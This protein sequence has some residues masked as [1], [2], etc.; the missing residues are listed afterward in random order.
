MARTLALATLPLLL[1]STALAQWATDTAANQVVRDAPSDQ[2]Q[3]KVVATGDGGFWVSWFD[4]LASGWDVRLQRYDLTGEA[5]FPPGGLLVADR[6]LSSTQDYGL[7]TTT[8]GDA[9]LAF[10]DDRGAGISIT[11]ARISR[12]GEQVWGPNGVTASTGSAFIASPRIVRATARGAVVAWTETSGV[13]VQRLNESG[14]PAWGAGVMIAPGLGSYALADMAPFV[15]DTI[16]SIVHQT[17]GFTSPR[18]LVAQ[19]LD[20]F[21]QPVW[22]ASPVPVFDAGSL[23][24]GSFPPVTALPDGGALFAWYS[25]SPTLQ[26]FVQRLDGS[27]AP[28]FA[29]NGVPVATTPGAVRVNPRASF[30]TSTGDVLVAWREQDPGQSMAGISAQRIDTSGARVWTDAG[31]TVVPTGPSLA[32]SPFVF[33]DSA[34]G[35][36]LVTWEESPS[37]GTD[38][39]YGARLDAMG[40]ISLPRFDIAS[41]PSGKARVDAARSTRDLV[42][43]AWSD[44]RS[45]G[46]DIYAQAIGIDGTPGGETYIVDTTCVGTVNFSG[47]PGKLIARGS[48]VVADDDLTLIAYDL[49]QHSFA[50]C[51]TSQVFAIV[52]MPG[53]SIG[54]LCLGGEIGRYVGPGQIMNSMFGGTFSLDLD[55]DRVPTPTGLVP[56]S[57]GE[58]WYFQAWFRDIVG[59]APRS[60]F[61]SGLR[62]VFQ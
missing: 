42:L 55:L 29:V 19:R 39:L 15:E 30:E 48:A 59:A 7:A 46:G 54:T 52:Q 47:L 61:T 56:V 33:A 4:G 21:G 6:S 32:G 40:A 5:A 24:L 8:D 57:S 16:L 41:T 22:G 50:F 38:R 13:R 28:T 43:L 31:A 1:P 58:T 44:A 25:S 10:R 14:A 9:I 27:G 18:H 34:T 26:S 62:I 2:N 49:P 17:G 11:A 37:F 53:N 20:R 45:D 23:Q 51:L 36:A 12:A 60:N 35:E 3:V